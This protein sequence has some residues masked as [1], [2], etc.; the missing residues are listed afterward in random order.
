MQMNQKRC[1][2]FILFSIT[3]VFV[4]K[5]LPFKISFTMLTMCICD[6]YD[7]YNGDH[8]FESV[9]IKA[10][11]SI[12]NRNHRNPTQQLI[13]CI[14]F[15]YSSKERVQLTSYSTVIRFTRFVTFHMQGFLDFLSL[16]NSLNLNA[17]V[18]GFL[19]LNE[20]TFFLF[21]FNSTGISCQIVGCQMF[22][23]P[24]HKK[25]KKQKILSQT[26]VSVSLQVYNKKTVFVT[27]FLFH[28]RKDI[29]ITVNKTIVSLMFHQTS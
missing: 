13:S 5:I 27:Y 29:M 12:Y 20:C 10:S 6:D 9:R 26:K 19:S 3:L 2:F 16:L 22:S 23:A 17:T 1:V 25:K 7:S 8:S 18:L 15:M 24:F 14:Y 28:F 11:S 21:I 4:S